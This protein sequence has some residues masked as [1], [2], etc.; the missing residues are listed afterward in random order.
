MEAPL[1]LH[2]PVV[3]APVAELPSDGRRNWWGT[4]NTANRVL[5]F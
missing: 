5:N 4:A 1:T 2:I 3:I